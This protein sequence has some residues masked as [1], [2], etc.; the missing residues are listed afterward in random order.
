MIFK[1]KDLKVGYKDTIV[2]NDI[3]IELK[4]GEILCVLGQNGCGKS[5]ILKTI[6]RQ[7]NSLD[8]KISVLNK[9]LI[10]MNNKELAK[11]ISVVLTDR[12]S[13]E[14]VTGEEIVA[15]GRYPHTGKL[16]KLEKADYKKIN[17]AIDLVNG[18]EL[19]H[20][21]FVCM[22]DG[23][24]QRMMIARAICQEPDIIVLD[25]PT[26]FLDIKYKIELLHLLSNLALYQNKTIIMS[27][28]EIDLVS[29]IADK[30]ILI[31]D[32][33]IYKEGLPEEVLTDENIHYAYDIS[34][35]NFN[36]KIGYIELPKM[37]SEPNIF[38]VG[39]QGK[40][41]PIYRILNRNGL[42]FYSGIIHKN[43]IDYEISK[44]ISYKTIG[45]RSFMPIS[46]ENIKLAKSY[47][48]KSSIIIDVGSEF[49]GINESNKKLIDYALGKDM[50]V[51][52]YKSALRRNQIKQVEYLD[53]LIEVIR[54]SK[55]SKS[56]R[57]NT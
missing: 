4:R 9:N 27:L 1:L 17:E 8:G 6:I 39:G 28:H 20:K 48:D 15:T 3:D 24:K 56:L 19:R 11:S 2:V 35:G 26:S 47:I 43:D 31:K 10:K 54:N 42:S 38:V 57:P 22:S 50:L 55:E 16:G 52:G 32:N 37:D 7:I 36:S 49:I 41:I 14:L 51:I 53:S 30:V 33:N 46:E 44:S 25:E 12:I 13:P 40:G 34:Q 21:E 29:K 18:E 23:E 45:E 5:T